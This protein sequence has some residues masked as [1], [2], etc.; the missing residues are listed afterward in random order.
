VGRRS[1]L[2]MGDVAAAPWLKPLDGGDEMGL[3]AM[4]T[5]EPATCPTRRTVRH[6]FL[7]SGAPAEALRNRG[8]VPRFL[9]AP[10]RK[11]AKTGTVLRKAERSSAASDRQKNAINARQCD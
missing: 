1:G 7:F 8:M 3:L 11:C 5:L 6:V 10:L 4:C 9:F 2:P